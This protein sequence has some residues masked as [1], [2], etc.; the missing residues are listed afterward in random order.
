MLPNHDVALGSSRSR[1]L[2]VKAGGGNVNESGNWGLRI[3]G[4]DEVSGH[5]A[6][7]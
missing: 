2:A 5:T 7:E 4:K 1:R 3:H 6:N